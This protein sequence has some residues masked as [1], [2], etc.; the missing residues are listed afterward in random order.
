[1][2]EKALNV[3]YKIS[4][5]LLQDLLVTLQEGSLCAHGGGIPLPIQNALTYFDD[6]LKPYFS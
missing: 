3:E 1:M 6:E 4:R 2:T 5:K